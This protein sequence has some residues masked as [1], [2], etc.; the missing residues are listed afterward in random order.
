VVLAGGQS[1]EACSTVSDG[2]SDLAQGAGSGGADF[3]IRRTIERGMPIVPAGLS[4]KRV[5]PS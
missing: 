3:S 5:S 2:G 1:A 4:Y